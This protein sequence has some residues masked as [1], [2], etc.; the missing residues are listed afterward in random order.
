MAKRK[1]VSEKDCIFCKIV[2]K[3]IPS[4]VF[5]DEGEYMAFLTPFPNTP[6]VTVVIPKKHITDYVFDMEGKDYEP[7]MKVVKKVARRMD[8]VFGVART[9]LIFEGTEIAHVHVKLYP[10]H[11]SLAG[12]T[13][14]LAPKKEFTELY[15]G[16]LT[17]IDGP[18]MD[19]EKLDELRG[20]LKF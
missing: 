19:D 17:T 18:K 9:A 20:K 3:E 13:Q 10:L 1:Q 6:G 14:V 8:D 2:R 7:F 12:K 5:F 16:Y 15:R 11:G 4:W